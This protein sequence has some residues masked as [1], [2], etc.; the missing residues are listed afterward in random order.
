MNLAIGTRN[1]PAAVQSFLLAGCGATGGTVTSIATGAG[2]TGG[3]I[4]T[5][6]TINLTANQL[7]P[8]TACAAN[9]IAK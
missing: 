2:L 1:T 6:G 8:T 3:P 9:Q 4:S 5:S 7:L